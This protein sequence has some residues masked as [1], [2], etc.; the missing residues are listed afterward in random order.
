MADLTISDVEEIQRYLATTRDDLFS[1]L[2]ADWAPAWKSEAA[3][4]LLN[5]EIGDG[6]T[7]WGEGP[8]RTTYA[9]AHALIHAAVDCLDA[10]AD[11]TNLST[12]AYVPHVI[13]R[14]A[15]E[16]GSQA[17]WLLE[18]NIGARRRVIRSLLIREAS[19]QYLEKAALELDPLHGSATSY[20]EDP[21]MV[22]AYANQL[23]VTLSSVRING[24]RRLACEGEILPTYTERA[25]ELQIAVFAPAAYAIYSGAAH[26][27]LYAVSQ[28]WRPST[29]AHNLWERNPDRIVVWA[30]AIVAAGF[31]T[32]PALRAIQ[33]LGRNARR[34]DFYYHM[35]N[36]NTMVQKMGLPREWR[37]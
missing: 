34:I 8:V 26:A 22:A 24:R 23:A 29:S 18:P 9:A 32:I 37:P 28:A 1:W 30:A 13:A 10:L 20:G 36:I 19:A 11:S 16:A 35:Q 4:E 2:P 17:W 7:P 27:E 3:G 21:A 15:M 31:A 6:G 5:G 25:T 12:T 14:A 33:L